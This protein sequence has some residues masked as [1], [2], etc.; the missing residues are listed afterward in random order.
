MAFVFWLQTLL[1]INLSKIFPLKG[2]KPKNKGHTKFY[3]CCDLT[4]KVYMFLPF[5]NCCRDIAL[6]THSKLVVCKSFKEVAETSSAKEWTKCPIML[7]WK[8]L[9]KI[10]TNFFVKCNYF[11][12][13]NLEGTLPGKN[14]IL[15]ILMSLIHYMISKLIWNNLVH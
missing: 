3:E 1:W 15:P 12:F 5:L 8:Q 6:V 7:M 13:K 9:F 14:P 4:K 11:F 2:L 10:N